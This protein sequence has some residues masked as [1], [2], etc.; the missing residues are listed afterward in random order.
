MLT[1]TGKLVGNYPIAITAAIDLLTRK[2][3]YQFS[4]K[5]SIDYKDI[6][7]ALIQSYYNTGMFAEAATEM[8]ILDSS[9]APHSADPAVLLV[10]I[11]VLS[12]SL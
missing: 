7:M 3:N 11:Q 5:T 1:I 8:D 4:H 12:G 10:A 6:R 2:E 9:N